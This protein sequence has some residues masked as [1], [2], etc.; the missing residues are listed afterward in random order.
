MEFGGFL[1]T[2]F[3]ILIL[4]LSE[5]R[6]NSMAIVLTTTK[7]LPEKCRSLCTLIGKTLHAKV[8]AFLDI[9]VN[10]MDSF[11]LHMFWCT[12]IHCILCF[13]DK[14]TYQCSKKKPRRFN[15]KPQLWMLCRELG[16]GMSVQCLCEVARSL[17]NPVNIWQWWHDQSSPN[18]LRHDLLS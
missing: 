5:S 1:S 4:T 8:V 11:T 13:L 3:K 7:S 17:R 12:L 9:K 14:K 6:T 18:F 16:H 2:I 15:Y 10:L